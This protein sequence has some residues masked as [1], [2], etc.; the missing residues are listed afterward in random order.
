MINIS[1]QDMAVNSG[2]LEWKLKFR[3]GKPT[4]NKLI[5]V[6]TR[7]NNLTE[8]LHELG[9]DIQVSSQTLIERMVE[10]HKLLVTRP[11]GIPVDQT[12]V[13]KP[14]VKETPTPKPAGKLKGKSDRVS[15]WMYRFING[16]HDR[17]TLVKAFR[18]K[19]PAAKITDDEI[20]SNWDKNHPSKPAS[21]TPAAIPAS[22]II[23]GSKV[24]QVKGKDR[25]NGT[26]TVCGVR[27]NGATFRVQFQHRTLL[28]PADH[29]ELV[30]GVAS[31]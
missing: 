13:E 29:F 15:P 25:I 23:V 3:N 21:E 2:G 11:A 20:L 9:I 22:G 19:F 5:S 12:P 1:D 6:L 7:I 16:W 10:D 14:E 28:L 30:T 18:E 8:V 31:S 24:K 4:A 26:G 27:D 17:N